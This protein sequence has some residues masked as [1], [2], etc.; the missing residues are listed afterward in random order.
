MVNEKQKP[1]KPPLSPARVIGEFLAG[2]IGA[3]VAS[4]PV[5]SHI[6]TE[7]KCGEVEWAG[8]GL[9]FQ[10]PITYP[11]GSLISIAGVYIVGNIRNQ[12][13]SFWATLGY[14][15][16]GFVAAAVGLVSCAAWLKGQWFRGFGALFT[17]VIFAAPTVG[18]VVGFNLTRK[19][20]PPLS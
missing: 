4:A 18:A 10:L 3:I 6:Y 7:I 14:S 19:Y 11:L 12:T 1:Q 15:L 9:I 8:L 5:L 20:K 2:S 17:I 13:A 16:L